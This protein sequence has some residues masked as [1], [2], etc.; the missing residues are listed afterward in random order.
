MVLVVSEGNAIDYLKGVVGGTTNFAGKVALEA[1]ST[2]AE[3]TRFVANQLN[4]K[5][6][7][8]AGIKSSLPRRPRRLPRHVGDASHHA[9]ASLSGGLR[10][11]HNNIVAVPL[12]EYQN[13]GAGGAARSALKG[14]PVGVLAPVAGVSEALSYTLLGLRNQ[15]RP[16]IRKEDEASLR[17][18][19]YD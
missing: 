13:N 9:Y 1:L 16:D 7:P 4:S 10:E 11:G 12:R 15:L 19:N 6:L 18:L 14:I 17:G 2:N 5:A 8:S 3:I